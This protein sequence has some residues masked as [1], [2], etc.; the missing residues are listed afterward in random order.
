MEIVILPVDL[1]EKTGSAECR[2]LRRS[3]KLPV[4]LYGMDRPP[5]N[6]SLDAHKFDLEFHR[7]KR[8]FEL[9]LGDKTQVSLLKDVAYNA[10]GDRIEHADFVRIDD[11]K[12]VTVKVAVEFVGVPAPMAG[13]VVDYITRDISIT[14]LPRQIPPSVQVNIGSLTVGHHVEAGQVTLPEGVTLV[15][16]PAKTL[17]AY[18]Y[19]SV[20]AAPAEAVGTAEPVVLTEKKPTD[21]KA[22]APTPAAADKKPAA[23]KKK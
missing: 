12:P 11:K 6:F 1:R 21:A 8:M 23:P 9:K 17:V 19:K 5:G 10:I 20:E 2:R 3:G 4:V 14:C 16:A 22:G 13:A 18:H 15:D 7:G